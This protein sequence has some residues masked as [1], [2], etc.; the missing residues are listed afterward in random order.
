MAGSASESTTVSMTTWL[1]AR[2]CAKAS[3]YYG[4]PTGEVNG[5]RGLAACEGRQEGVD[6]M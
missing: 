6:L 3:S 5:A 2:E 1:F 4:E